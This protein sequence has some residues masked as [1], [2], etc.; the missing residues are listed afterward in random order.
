MPSRTPSR[1]ASAYDT[2]RVSVRVATPGDEAAVGKLLAATYPRLMAPGYEPDVLAAALP[3]MIKANPAL[4]ASGTYYL[5][6]TPEGAV[7]GCG[8]WT[9]DRPG[10]ASPET[11][12]SPP[13]DAAGH[14]R[15]F[16][17]HPDWLRQGI[18]RKL[19]ERCAADAVSDGVRRFECYASLV[20]VAFYARMGFSVVGPRS[21]PLGAQ[22]F[23]VTHMVADLPP[24]RPAPQVARPDAVGG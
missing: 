1:S 8:G 7:V 15:H 21:I 13:S 3:A 10:G 19:F 18:G 14:I 5:A 22:G 9:H 11:D 24:T 12:A 16:A 2:V 4:L 23:P 20:A 6:E 17:T